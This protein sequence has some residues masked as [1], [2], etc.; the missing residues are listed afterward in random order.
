MER[1]FKIHEHV[2]ADT[3]VTTGYSGWELAS[4]EAEGTYTLWEA[5]GEGNCHVRFEWEVER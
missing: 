1:K 5:A 2:P 3:R 4:P